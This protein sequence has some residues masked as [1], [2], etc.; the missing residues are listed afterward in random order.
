MA[1]IISYTSFYCLFVAFLFTY[2][3]LGDNKNEANPNKDKQE[4]SGWQ[5]EFSIKWEKNRNA[6]NS[7]KYVMLKKNKIYV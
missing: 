5:V 1:A 6:T 7:A 4:Q 3:I 2:P